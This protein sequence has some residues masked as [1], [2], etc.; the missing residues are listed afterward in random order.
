MFFCFK[1]ILY[2]RMFSGEKLF[3]LTVLCLENCFDVKR[4]SVIFFYIILFIVV[5]YY[6]MCSNKTIEVYA[7]NKLNKNNLVLFQSSEKHKADRM[8]GAA[9]IENQELLTFRGV[10]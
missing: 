7:G 5:R 3:T 9:R 2:L 8:R 6:I 4:L 1:L 10:L